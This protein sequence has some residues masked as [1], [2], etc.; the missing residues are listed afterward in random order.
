MSLK[1]VTKNIIFNFFSY[2]E[3]QIKYIKQI[4]YKIYKTEFYFK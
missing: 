2:T 3:Y 4:W 1:Y